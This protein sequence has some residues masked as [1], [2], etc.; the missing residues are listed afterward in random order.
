MNTGYTILN[1]TVI[2]KTR[3]SPFILMFLTSYT[4][5]VWLGRKEFRVALLLGLG[6]AGMLL[7][8]LRRSASPRCCPGLR[9]AQPL[10][11]GKIFTEYFSFASSRSIPSSVHIR[12]KNPTINGEVFTS[13]T[14]GR[15]RTYAKGF[16]DLRSTIKLRPHAL[17]KLLFLSSLGRLLLPDKSQTEDTVHDKRNYFN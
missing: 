11:A 6:S 17:T 4:W 12:S 10:S 9:T 8:F 1:I 7:A 3:L 16:G 15:N 13:G 5:P 14:G 2:Q